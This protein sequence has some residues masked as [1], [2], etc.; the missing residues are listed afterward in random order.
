MIDLDPTSFGR[1]VAWWVGGL[2]R[3]DNTVYAV[4]DGSAC[5]VVHEMTML[6]FIDA[7]L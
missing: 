7:L 3:D 6:C 1:F 5:S 4:V 2:L